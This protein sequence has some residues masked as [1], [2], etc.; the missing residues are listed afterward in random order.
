MSVRTTATAFAPSVAALDFAPLHGVDV[1]AVERAAELLA[2]FGDTVVRR[3]CTP[4]E[5][6]WVS[7]TPRRLAVLLGLKESAIKA[8]AGR[9]DGFRW[10]MVETSAGELR[11]PFP[12]R[13]GLPDP[14][15]AVLDG[16]AAGI[17]LSEVEAVTV[18][19]A[20]PALERADEL[21]PGPGELLGA[22]VFG[23]RDGHLFAATTF[24][25][26]RT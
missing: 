17:G 19:L 5:A 12:R 9:P 6:S 24:W 10:Q 1:V 3:V 13:A 26:D 8:I 18:R 25:R 11:V 23:V 4:S 22:G 14:V 20:K 21:L 16:F 7:L 15:H 2:K